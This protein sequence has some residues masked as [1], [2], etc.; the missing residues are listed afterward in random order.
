MHDLH[1]KQEESVKEFM[2]N[3]ATLAIALNPVFPS[4]AF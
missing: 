3:Q 2:N 1:L 4:Q